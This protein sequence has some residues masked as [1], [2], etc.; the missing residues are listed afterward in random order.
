MKSWE[1]IFFLVTFSLSVAARVVH[2]EFKKGYYTPAQL[3]SL[4]Q[5][6]PREFLPDSNYEVSAYPVPAYGTSSRGWPSR[7]S[8]LLQHVSR[9][10]L[11]HDATS[12][13]RRELGSRGQED[14]RNLWRRNSR[15]QHQENHTVPPGPLHSREPRTWG[16]DQYDRPIESMTAAASGQ[17]TE[18]SR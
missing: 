15:R 5:S 12:A 2:P 13:A 16:T 14:E 18:P 8:D 3:G 7:G 1:R 17:R 11:H 9:P 6:A 10:A 4:L